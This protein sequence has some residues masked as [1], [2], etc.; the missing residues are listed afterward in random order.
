MA[1]FVYARFTTPQ[2]VQMGHCGD[3]PIL[4]CCADCERDDRPM[5][6]GIREEDGPI[7]VI[8][9]SGRFFL[10]YFCEECWAR[11]LEP[12]EAIPA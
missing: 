10:A 12:T 3:V 1:A 2:V 5:A 6:G 11:R 8:E 4:A 9:K 7:A